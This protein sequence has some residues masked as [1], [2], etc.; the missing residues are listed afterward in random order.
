MMCHELLS[1]CI[2]DIDKGGNPTIQFRHY[3]YALLLLSGG[4]LYV[5]IRGNA[6]CESVYLGRVN[7]CSP[8]TCDVSRSYL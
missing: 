2:I 6:E 7:R 1:C 4:R 5:R 8:C 3:R